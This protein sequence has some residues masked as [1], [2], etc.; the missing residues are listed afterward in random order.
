MPVDYTIYCSNF[1]ENPSSW[2]S[3]QMPMF[4]SALQLHILPIQFIKLS[5]NNFL[6]EW[7][8]YAVQM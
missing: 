5:V 2:S 3:Q 1:T 4:W 6:N 7:Q 8:A